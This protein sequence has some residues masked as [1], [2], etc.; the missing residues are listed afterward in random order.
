VR[1]LVYKIVFAVNIL[2]AMALLISYLSV[3]I[4][5]DAFAFPALMGLAYPY[6]LLINILFALFWLILLRFEAF[7]SVA[8][9]AIGFT[10][11]SNYIKL[12]RLRV[13]KPVLSKFLATISDCLIIMKTKTCQLEKK[14]MELLKNQQPEISVFRSFIFKAICKKRLRNLDLHSETV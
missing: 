14:V 4:R 6:L 12:S 13:T 2:F 5:P 11:F 7:I 3:H 8:V 10:H 1:K 9:I